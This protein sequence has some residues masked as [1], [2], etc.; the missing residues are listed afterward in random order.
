MTPRGR[1]IHKAI[2]AKQASGERYRRNTASILL[3][4]AL[5]I[6]SAL[7]SKWLPHSGNFWIDFLPAK[8]VLDL[9]GAVPDRPT[10]RPPD[11]L[12]DRPDRPTDRPTDRLP[13]RGGALLS[14]IH[15]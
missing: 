12:T 14:L 2:F 4:T 13:A 9:D 7:T 6:F 11:L 5:R 15:I 3:A 10:A 1:R 8:P